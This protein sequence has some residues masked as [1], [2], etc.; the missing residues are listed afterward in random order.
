MS[1]MASLSVMVRT[2]LSSSSVGRKDALFKYF[3]PRR[4][5][6]ISHVMSESINVP[7]ISNIA[8]LILYFM[9]LELHFH[10]VVGYVKT[11][12]TRDGYKLVIACQTVV[13]EVVYDMHGFLIYSAES[14]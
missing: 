4:D 11:L 14:G 5:Y 9:L 2:V 7:S 10:A 12:F 1:D 8:H 3:L 13:R 6:N